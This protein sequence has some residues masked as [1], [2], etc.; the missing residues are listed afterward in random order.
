MKTAEIPNMRIKD[1]CNKIEAATDRNDHNGAALHL[2][3]FV[4]QKFTKIVK[5][6]QVIHEHEGSMP[7]P[8][9]EY[10]RQVIKNMLHCV[11]Q[12]HGEEVA[13]QINSSF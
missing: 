7:F 5:A 8:L 10:R 3:E 6:I 9:V 11:T 13:I 1:L 4:G 12:Q 2:A